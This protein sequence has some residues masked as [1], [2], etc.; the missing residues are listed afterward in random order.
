MFANVYS[1]CFTIHVKPLMTILCYMISWSANQTLQLIVN[2]ML[3]LFFQNASF[4][5]LN[6]YDKTCW[7]CIQTVPIEPLAAI[8]FL[9]GWFG[10]I[11]HIRVNLDN[12]FNRIPLRLGLLEIYCTLQ[13]SIAVQCWSMHTNSVTL[14]LYEHS[15]GGSQLIFLLVVPQPAE[16][17]WWPGPFPVRNNFQCYV[18]TL[19]K[20]PTRQ[21]IRRREIIAANNLLK[22]KS[23]SFAQ[24]PILTS[25]LVSHS[26]VFAWS[27]STTFTC[28]K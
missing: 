10:N 4:K 18:H 7:H 6:C 9:V 26:H 15:K 3:L 20:H 22:L 28:I 2:W 16:F 19:Y 5:H 23:V 21:R 17:L 27:M 24:F 8:W 14:G 12:L 1:V 13:S 25:R 11:Q